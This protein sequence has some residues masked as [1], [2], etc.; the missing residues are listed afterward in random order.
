MSAL[1]DLLEKVEAGWP[2]D[3][4]DIMRPFTAVF[5]IGWVAKAALDANNGSLDAALALHNAVLPDWEWAVGSGIVYICKDGVGSFGFGGV[6]FERPLA[7][8]P[9]C[10]LLI[11]IL[12]ALIAQEGKA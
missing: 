9:A 7:H 10:A 5:D 2:V 1:T 8:V 12:K 3:G 6:I 4:E 11:S